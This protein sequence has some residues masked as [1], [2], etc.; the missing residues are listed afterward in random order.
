MKKFQTI[1]LL[2]SLIMIIIFPISTIAEDS[3]D[4]DIDKECEM[5]QDIKHRHKDMWIHIQFYY[6]LLL[7][8]Y[9]P[10]LKTEWKEIMRERETILKKWKELKKEGKEFDHSMI[11]EEWKEKHQQYHEAFL[12]AVKIRDDE[13]IKSLLPKLLELQK[14]WNRDQKRVLQEE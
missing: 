4:D 7:D 12:E 10:E 1:T 14:S 8:K 13:K 11:S 2:F 9:H 3:S 5:N 6:E